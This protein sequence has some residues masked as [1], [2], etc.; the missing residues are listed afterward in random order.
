[1][2]K[3]KLFI[4]FDNTV[5]ESTKQFCRVYNTLYANHP[6]F[7]PAD[8][9]KVLEYNFK[10]VCPLIE[11]PLDIF[12]HP[13]FFSSLEFYNDNTYEVLEKLNKKYQLII[14][15]IG[16][17]KNLALKCNW[18]ENNLP[19]IKDYVLVFNEG[20]HMN[21]N[22]I[23]MKDSIFIDD[24]PSNLLSVNAREKILFGKIYPW[25]ADGLKYFKHCLTWSDVEKRLL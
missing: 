9:T 20:C 10:D 7:K 17:P 3:N 25:N 6:E 2:S 18:L 1:M 11:N 23:N 12:E 13:L 4:D 19:F 24:I 21:K 8:Y 14:A 22:V 16:S 5:C 15:T